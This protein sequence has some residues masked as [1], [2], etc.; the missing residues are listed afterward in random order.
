MKAEKYEVIRLT[1][2]FFFV[3]LSD[4]VDPTVFHGTLRI[5][6]SG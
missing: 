1:V 2:F 3:L 6:V 4:H 5:F